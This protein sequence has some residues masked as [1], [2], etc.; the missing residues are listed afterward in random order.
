[1]SI[2]PSNLKHEGDAI[3]KTNAIHMETRSLL[4]VANI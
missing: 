1:M 2:N 3:M 4:E